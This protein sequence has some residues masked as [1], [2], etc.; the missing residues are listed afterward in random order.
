MKRIDQSRMSGILSAASKATM[1]GFV[2]MSSSER[3]RDAYVEFLANMLAFV[4]ALV[5]LSLIGKYIWNNVIVDL[6]SF[7]KPAKSF[8]QIIGLMIFVA[9]VRP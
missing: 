1:D 4:I 6:F 8:W 5:L 9:L 3:K 2:G 7:A